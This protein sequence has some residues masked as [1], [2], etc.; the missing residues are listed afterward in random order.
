[1]LKKKPLGRDDADHGTPSHS[2]TRRVPR[3][4]V[5]RLALVTRAP[6][7]LAPPPSCECMSRIDRY[8]AS[9]G[10][11]STSRVSH[12]EISR[13]ILSSAN[14]RTN[15]IQSPAA[16]ADLPSPAPFPIPQP[17]RQ[18]WL[19][20]Q[21]RPPQRQGERRRVLP[22]LHAGR[23]QDG[24]RQVRGRPQARRRRGRRCRRD[25]CARY[26]PHLRALS[27]SVNEE[28]GGRVRSHVVL[29]AIVVE[30]VSMR[31]TVELKYTIR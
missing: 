27:G 30:R 10:P 18:G 15:P 22:H 20:L 12:G 2:S 31:T 13:Q 19:R 3:P 23:V 21:A 6:P 1:M 8:P 5:A 11:K 7:R 17:Q 9:D 28:S 26:P 24:R 25:W 16:E 14:C 4:R 29:L